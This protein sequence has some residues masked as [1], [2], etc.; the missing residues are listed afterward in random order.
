MWKWVGVGLGVIGLV[1]LGWV[2]LRKGSETEG[3][4]PQVNQPR[5]GAAPVRGEAKAAP[6]PRGS[7]AGRVTGP[8][9]K[10]LAAKVC[11]APESGADGLPSC[12]AAGLDGNYRLIDVA[13]GEAAVAASARGYLPSVIDVTL[14]DT[15]AR[16][17][18]DFILVEGGVEVRG[19]VEDVGGGGIV[20]ADV[21]VQAQA[22]WKL[23][24]TVRS[25]DRGDF[26]FW[27]APVVLHLSAMA[28]GYAAETKV[29]H[30]PTEAVVFVL[31][32]GAILVGRVVDAAT[33]T[34]VAGASVFA[35]AGADDLGDRSPSTRTDEEGRFRLPQ[36]RPGRYKPMARE[37]TRF[38]MAAE[39]VLLGLGQ[40][41]SE[42]V[43]A[44]GPAYSVSGQ[45]VIA[46]SGEPCAG[47]DV[48][49]SLREQ[50]QSL[51]PTA[52][53]DEKGAIAF[54]GLVPGTY[55]VSI[56][57]PHALWR[58]NDQVTIVHSD[59]T[60][61]TWE[62]QSG[63]RITGT[64]VDTAGAPVR[65]AQLMIMTQ[66]TR[67]PGRRVVVRDGS[68]AVNLE[69]GTHR[70]LA[71]ASGY[72]DESTTIV[73]S[74]ANTD[75]VR[76]VLARAGAIKGRVVDRS[77]HSIEGVSV[78]LRTS[79]WTKHKLTRDDGSF[80]VESAPAGGY[81]D[82]RLEIRFP[83]RPRDGHRR[84]D[85]GG[86][87]R[88]RASAGRDPR[89]GRGPRREAGDGQLGHRLSRGLQPLGAG[90][91]RPH[92]SGR[93]LQDRGALRRQAHGARSSAGGRGGRGPER[94]G[95]LDGEARH[96][97][98]LLDHGHSPRR[99][100]AVQHRRRGARVPTVGGVLPFGGPLR[101]A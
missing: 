17:G 32:P 70:V 67:L 76:L 8:D 10:G 18:L 79:E 20:D 81:R 39:S 42:V 16:T 77:G 44:I 52:K 5:G 55:G 96:E 47:A 63:S 36:L 35:G 51:Y 97:P 73:V 56:D 25:D 85:D 64:V 2:L 37:S 50:S 75:G 27:A 84:R 1:L 29:V 40:T 86:A 4:T 72:C 22:E 38:G 26:S 61:L 45:V 3:I 89:A 9:G 91:A 15:E 41:S 66:G 23:V 68:F 71:W 34:P 53:S 7:I 95:R 78:D 94:R 6:V 33:G 48:V 58:D 98:D 24:T 65:S 30:P 99:R 19:H 100:T 93:T 13:A 88:R 21:V 59:L 74:E 31:T 57:C 83:A 101:A 14:K 87:D 69:P 80:F 54:D 12:V 46:P 11:V 60:G 62:V 28:E 82:Q 49:L 43:V 90:R 92:R